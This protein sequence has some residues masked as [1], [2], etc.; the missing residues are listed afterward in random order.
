LKITHKST[1]ARTVDVRDTSP[2]QVFLYGDRP[3]LR[4]ESPLSDDQKGVRRVL[5]LTYA[6]VSTLPNYTKVVPVE[7]ELVVE[8]PK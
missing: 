3:Y 8:A 4:C 2:G 7:A 6:S 1:E 5:D